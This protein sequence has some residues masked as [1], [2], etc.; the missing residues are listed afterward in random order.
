MK[1]YENRALLAEY[2]AK[3]ATMLSKTETDVNV[4]AKST[5]KDM[6]IEKLKEQLREA[7]KPTN[8]GK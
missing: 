8:E 1:Q 6:E 3:L 2:K 7:K 5:E 4:A